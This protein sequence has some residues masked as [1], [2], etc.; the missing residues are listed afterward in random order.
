[1][2]TRFL[3]L[4]C[5]FALISTAVFAQDTEQPA[6]GAAAAPQAEALTTEEVSYTIGVL[7]GRQMEYGEQLLDTDVMVRA[8]LDVFADK[9][10][11]MTDAEMQSV[12]TRLSTVMQETRAEEFQA[13]GTAYLEAKRDEPGVK[14]TGSGLMYKVIEEG[15]GES[16]E[17]TDTVRV[18]YTGKFTDGTVFDSSEGGEPV[19]FQLNQVIP[20]WTEGLQL[21]KE[22]AT[23]EF[24]IPYTLAY[25]EAGAPRGGIPPYA[26]LVFEVKLLEVVDEPAAQ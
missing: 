25:G 20:G 16:P 5:A 10:L 4:A 9:E 17:P 22:G 24:Y 18:H 15:S 13:E 3:T 11:E 12:L 21:M 7:F 6:P 14:V 19:Q 8:M 23:Y 26:T 2:L 1:M